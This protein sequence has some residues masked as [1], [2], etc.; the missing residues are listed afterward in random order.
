MQ[1]FLAK[2]EL[3]KITYYR[4]ASTNR[5]T[6][7]GAADYFYTNTGSGFITTDGPSSKRIYGVPVPPYGLLERFYNNL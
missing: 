1:V 4:S 2:Q 6:V 7:N 3:V 5:I